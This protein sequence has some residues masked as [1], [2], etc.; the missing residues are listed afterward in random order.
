[1]CSQEH[2]F[3][4]VNVMKKKIVW[5][6]PKLV[7][8][9]T[10]YDRALGVCETGGSADPDDDFVCTIGGTVLAG[11]QCIAGNGGNSGG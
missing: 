9:S 8:L 7:V 6:E 2:R 3:E 11:G 5:C 10:R 1:M 4:E